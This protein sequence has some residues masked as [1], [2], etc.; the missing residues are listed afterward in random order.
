MFVG[1]LV[2][3]VVVTVVVF[4]F[5]MVCYDVTMDEYGCF[6]QMDFLLGYYCV[7]VDMDDFGSQIFRVLV[8]VGGVVDVYFVLEVG[9]VVVFWLCVLRDD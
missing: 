6:E 8:Y 7:S 2:F 1:E 3:V 5:I 4:G 9:R